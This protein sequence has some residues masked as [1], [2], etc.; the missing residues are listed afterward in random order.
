MKA[1]GVDHSG[2]Y[3]WLA[4]VGLALALQMAVVGLL[5]LIGVWIP[6]VAPA[7]DP[8][9]EV[10]IAAEVPPMVDRALEAAAEVGGQQGWEA[11]SFD[12]MQPLDWLERLA[13]E[14]QSVAA[15]D[16]TLSAELMDGLDGLLPDHLA[17]GL[18]AVDFG[19]DISFTF[20][21]LSEAA[22]RVVIAFD[23]SLSVVNDMRDAGQP[24]ERVRDETDRLIND[25][26]ALVQF[27]MVQFARNHSWFAAEM[28]PATAAVRADA[29]AWLVREFRTDGRAGYG[30]QRGQPYNGIQAV[31]AEAFERKPEVVI[32]VSNGR[33][34]RSP[35]NQPVPWDEL[36]ADLRR[37][38]RQMDSPARIHFIGYGVRD[39]VRPRL[40]ELLR[41]WR[42]KLVEP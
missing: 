15:N 34:F 39:D 32:I 10:S 27:G 8:G 14:G 23:I 38:Q 22:E 13:V 17:D 37:L 9:L 33:F 16:W 26:S 12:Q 19:A 7:G 5:A 2:R 28:Q 31:L 21:G 30:W 35:G 18:A 36:A 4:V 20:L 11:N 3:V 1:G 42:G 25:L 41:P 6:G 29:R 40:R 24:I